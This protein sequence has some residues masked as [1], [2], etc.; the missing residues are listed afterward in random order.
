MRIAIINQHPDFTL[1]GSEIQ[2]DL[3]AQELAARGHEVYYLAING[4]TLPIHPI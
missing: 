2:C 3:F 1:G 4:H